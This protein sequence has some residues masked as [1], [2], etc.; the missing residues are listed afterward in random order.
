MNKA[1]REILALRRTMF[2][3]IA[4]GELIAKYGRHRAKEGAR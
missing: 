2:E 3:E 4:S 1:T